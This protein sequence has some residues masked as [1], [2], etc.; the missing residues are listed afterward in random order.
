MRRTDA[1]CWL[2]RATASDA[3]RQWPTYMGVFV[4]AVRKFPGSLR[5]CHAPLLASRNRWN[6][7]SILHTSN[8]SF[9]LHHRLRRKVLQ[10]LTNYFS[11]YDIIRQR[12][13]LHQTHHITWHMVYLPDK[14]FFLCCV[15]RV[16]YCSVTLYYSYFVLLFFLLCFVLFIVRVL[17]C[18]CLWC[19]CCYPNWGF[20]M[21]FPQ[22]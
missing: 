19:T 20:S 2:Q 8:K 3:A 15:F 4:W 7:L 9:A 5:A 14:D 18:V 6:A 22:L 13:L 11:R 10:T 16:L 17:C 1:Q 21:L 12:S